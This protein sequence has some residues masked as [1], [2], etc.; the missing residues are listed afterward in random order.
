MFSELQQLQSTDPAK[1]QQ[2]TGDIAQKLKSAAGSATGPAA[3][4]LSSLSDK[5]AQASQSGN[6][7]SLTPSQ[8][9]QS[10]ASSAQ[11]A[12]QK[13]SGGHHHHGGGGNSEVQQVME[14]ISQEVQ[15]AVS[16]S[17]ASTS[18]S[19]QS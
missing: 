6:L 10:G 15:Q 7:S 12:Y 5:F 8:G 11:A 9:S 19:A 4:F 13:H 3:Q 14:S 16:P 1:F 18:T 2:V 17:S